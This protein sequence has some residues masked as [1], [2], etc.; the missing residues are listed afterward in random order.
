MNLFEV[1]LHSL[2][3]LE[4]LGTVRDH[5]HVRNSFDLVHSRSDM[6]SKGSKV[7]LGSKVLLKRLRAGLGNKHFCFVCYPAK[8]S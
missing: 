8:F 1:R 4:K 3:E 5:R 6:P 7:G 2:K